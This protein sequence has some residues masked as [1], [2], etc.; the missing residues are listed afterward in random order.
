MSNISFTRK[1]RP[2]SAGSA[3]NDGEGGGPGITSIGPSGRLPEQEPE[4]AAYSTRFLTGNVEG[5]AT[6]AERRTQ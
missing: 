5:M 1:G 3:D 6:K 4:N 2:C